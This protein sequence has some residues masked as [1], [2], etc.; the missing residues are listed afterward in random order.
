M[1]PIHVSILQE[2]RTTYDK[3]GLMLTSAFGPAKSTAE[4]GYELHELSSLLDHFHIMCYDYHGAWDKK[5]NHNGPLFASKGEG[6]IDESLN[7]YLSQGVPASKIV[8][9]LPFYGR[10][11]LLDEN[12]L[13]DSKGKDAKYISGL[14][15]PARDVGF[16]GPYTKEDGFLGFNEVR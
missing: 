3:Y 8:L 13:R 5:A 1:Y 15:Q 6:S 10:T 9:G 16:Q 12:D 4:K 14:N 2:L 11:F 7:Y